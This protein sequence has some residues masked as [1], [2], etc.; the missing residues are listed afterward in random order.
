MFELTSLFAAIPKQRRA[1]GFSL[2]YTLS[3]SPKEYVYM[4]TLKNYSL[5]FNA[6]S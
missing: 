3:K 1:N 4:H 2:K 6:Y 5:I